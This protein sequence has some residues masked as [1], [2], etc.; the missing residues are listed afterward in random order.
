[1]HRLLISIAICFL[2]SCQYD[3]YYSQYASAKPT[4]TFVGTYV[5][6]KETKLLLA[7]MYKN[8]KKSSLELRSDSSFI[9]K[10]I[11]SVWSPLSTMGGFESVKGKWALVRHQEWWA[12]DLTVESVRETD[13][14]WSKKGFGMQAMLIGQHAPYKLHFIIGDPDAGKALQ[15]ELQ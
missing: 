11:A 15:Y 5:P 12:I 7:G 14:N 1:M 13:S 2:S 10:N 6:T 4:Q 8:V 3:P 9:I